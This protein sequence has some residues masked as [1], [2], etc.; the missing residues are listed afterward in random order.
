MCEREYVSVRNVKENRRERAKRG[1]QI[2]AFYKLGNKKIQYNPQSSLDNIHWPMEEP[3]IASLIRSY[4]RAMSM[5]VLLE[6]S[7]M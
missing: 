6:K 3:L 5:L 1:W 2:F 4:I 7:Y